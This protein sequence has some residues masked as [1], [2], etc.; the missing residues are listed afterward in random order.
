MFQPFERPTVLPCPL[1]NHITRIAVLVN[2]PIRRPG[3]IVFQRIGGKLGQRPDAQHQRVE[4]LELFSQ[5]IGRNP[6]KTGC[7]STLGH[8]NLAEFRR[9]GQFTNGSSRGDIFRQVK[10]TD[11]HRQRHPRHGR[12]QA[13][14]ECRNHRRHPGHG[15]T[16]VRFG[17]S[18]QHQRL[19]TKSS[20]QSPQGFRIRV[21]DSHPIVTRLDQQ[22]GDHSPDG[23]GTKQQYVCHRDLPPPAGNKQSAIA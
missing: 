19:D 11:P 5:M 14:G 13:K 1:M 10:I 23:S 8:E 6:H 17:R 16:Q 2:Q 4:F 20:L 9:G 22:G 3:Q 21:G 15:S 7:Q 18:I 12:I